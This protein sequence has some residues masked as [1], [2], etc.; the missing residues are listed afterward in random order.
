MKNLL[1]IICILF[2]GLVYSGEPR[3]IMYGTR[4]WNQGPNDTPTW[5]ER[6]NN[7]RMKRIHIY[8]NYT[9]NTS[10]M[11]VVPLTQTFQVDAENRKDREYASWLYFCDKKLSELLA[12]PIGNLTCYQLD[13]FYHCCGHRMKLAASNRTGDATNRYKDIIKLVDTTEQVLIAMAA[14]DAKRKS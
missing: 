8:A 12:T 9:V 1:I 11:P 6:W 13:E 4:P 5:Y 10:E 7:F 2:S 3:Q 14:F